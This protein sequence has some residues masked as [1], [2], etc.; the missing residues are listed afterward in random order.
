MVVEK[1]YLLNYECLLLLKLFHFISIFKI[2]FKFVIIF[3]KI[4]LII[5]VNF[6]VGL[7]IMCEQLFKP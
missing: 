4:N 2:K 5:I 3:K 1:N 7:N 6:E